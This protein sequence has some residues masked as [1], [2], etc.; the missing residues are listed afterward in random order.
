V[1]ALLAAGADANAR[2][3]KGVTALMLAGFRCHEGVVRLLK[4]AGAK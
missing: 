3:D 4:K 1:Q 2:T